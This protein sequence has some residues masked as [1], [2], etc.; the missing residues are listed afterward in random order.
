MVEAVF[1]QSG[2][3]GALV[4]VQLIHEELPAFPWEVSRTRTASSSS[5]PQA[6]HDFASQQDESFRRAVSEEAVADPA[7]EDEWQ[8]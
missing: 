3:Q 7:T 4:V 1:C 8:A 6:A 5:M 2:A